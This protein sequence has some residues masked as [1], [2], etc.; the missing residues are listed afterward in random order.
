HITKVDR[1][2]DPRER[3]YFWIEE[4]Q[5][6]W[7]PDPRSDHQA[8]KEKQVSVTPL[9]PDLTAHDVLDVLEALTQEVGRR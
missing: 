4:A 3:P 7:E 8:I 2:M 6:D 9:Q 1:R 5:D